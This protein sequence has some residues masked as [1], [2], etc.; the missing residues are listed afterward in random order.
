MNKNALSIF[1]IILAGLSF[2][3][4]LGVEKALLAVL[5]GLFAL[6]RTTE[7]RILAWIAI[8]LGLTFLAAVAA[9]TLFHL[10]KLTA[11]PGGM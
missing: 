5:I 8:G 10:P 9:I 1:A 7:S 4:L 11:M 2:F 6:S 3:N